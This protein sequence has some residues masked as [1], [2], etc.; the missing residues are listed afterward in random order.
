MSILRAALEIGHVAKMAET[1]EPPTVKIEF[2][3]QADYE[4]FRLNVER[5]PELSRFQD[6]RDMMNGRYLIAGVTFEVVLK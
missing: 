1:V 6:A 4:R 2:R 3:L 5:D